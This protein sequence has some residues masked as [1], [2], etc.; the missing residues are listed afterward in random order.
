MTTMTENDKRIALEQRIVRFMLRELSKAGWI[1]THV[2][3][4]DDDDP[5]VP[6]SGER[7]TMEEVTSV[8]TCSITFGKPY[9]SRVH[10]V[11]VVLG[12]GVDV[13]ADYSD[14]EGDNFTVTMDRITDLITEKYDQ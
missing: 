2:D 10:G 7:Q 13:I 9:S 8:D 6:V 12:N 14:Y 3:T 4:G 1:P 5:Y 11:L